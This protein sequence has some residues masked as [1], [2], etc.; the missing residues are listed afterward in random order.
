MERR[1][2][3][4]LTHL[5]PTFLALHAARPRLPMC[6]HLRSSKLCSLVVASE[7]AHC[8]G[9]GA[10]PSAVS[11]MMNKGKG[12]GEWLEVKGMAGARRYGLMWLG[13]PDSRQGDSSSLEV[14][15]V[16]RVV[17]DTRISASF[18]SCL[19]HYD[20]HKVL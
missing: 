1:T 19:Q 5:Y 7:T 4:R 6:D 11:F 3:V 12:R 8:P 17:P 16:N 20:P 10:L 15:L 13:D 18:S 2:T 9:F 14:Y